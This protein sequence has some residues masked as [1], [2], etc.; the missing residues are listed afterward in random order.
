MTRIA[1]STICILSLLQCGCG[2]NSATED[3]ETSGSLTTGGDSLGTPTDGM[4]DSVKAS[5]GGDMV[6]T[7]ANTK[8][9]FVGTHTDDTDPHTGEFQEFTGSAS[10][11]DGKLQSL[12]VD[13]DVD[14]IT[15][16]AD[17]LTT[18]LKSPDFF[19]ARENPTATFKSTSIETAED[20]TVT[21][22]GDL[23]MLKETKSISFPATVSLED[24]LKLSAEFAIDRTQFGMNYGT[25]KIKSEVAMTVTIGE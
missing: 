18:H 10:M 11:A 24:G 1:L 14:S 3:T 19:N 7:P 25:D 16:D 8:I 5:A 17:K 13:I 20:G 9:A 21:V 15:T 2:D 22:T 4:D 12:S 6:L 23:T